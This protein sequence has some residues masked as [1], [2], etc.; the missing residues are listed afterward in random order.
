MLD[1]F[2]KFYLKLKLQKNKTEIL[3]IATLVILLFLGLVMSIY[4]ISKPYFTPRS[5]SLSCN[6]NYE[7]TLDKKYLFKNTTKQIKLNPQTSTISFKTHEWKKHIGRNSCL[8]NWSYSSILIIKDVN[9]NQIKPF[10]NRPIFKMPEKIHNWN[11]NEYSKS[12]MK[13]NV[14]T[15]NENLTY[16]F[17]TYLKNPSNCFN[18]EKINYSG[19]DY[20]YLFL[21]FFILLIILGLLVAQNIIKLNKKGK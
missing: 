11:P 21:P 10:D 14:D 4:C 9:H 13:K 17:Q 12:R 1:L 6:E 18:V 15:K 20:Q 19:F 2:N 7:C 5:E 8:I 16:K 3:G